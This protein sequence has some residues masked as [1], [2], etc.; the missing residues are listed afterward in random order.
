MTT[1]WARLSRSS[2]SGRGG[3]HPRGVRRG[4]RGFRTRPTRRREPGLRPRR[5]HGAG[6][7]RGRERAVM[8]APQ[9]APCAVLEL[10]H[11]PQDGR[12]HRLGGFIL[13]AHDGQDGHVVAPPGDAAVHGVPAAQHPELSVEVHADVVGDV[14]PPRVRWWKR[15]QLC[16]AFAISS[17]ERPTFPWWAGQC[18]S[19]TRTEPQLTLAR[20][21]VGDAA[22]QSE[23]G[24]MVGMVSPR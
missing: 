23:R 11:H 1:W 9:G 22:P 5:Q 7:G 6:T 4:H 15:C 14:L 8:C 13:G 20:G 2:P 3:Q 18:R 19:L 21:R 24:W 17:G 16:S 12:L 10:R